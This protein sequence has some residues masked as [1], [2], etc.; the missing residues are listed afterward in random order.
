MAMLCFGLYTSQ[1]IAQAALVDG[2]K[3]RQPIQEEATNFHT[4]SEE[5]K[6][7][8]LYDEANWGPLADSLFETGIELV[9]FMLPV[10]NKYADENI[11]QPG[12]EVIGLAN[13]A[14]KAIKGAP[15]DGKEWNRNYLNS[16]KI[17]LE[18]ST[19]ALIQRFDQY[20]YTSL[21]NSIPI[22]R[23]AKQK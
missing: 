3:E 6:G 16:D 17:I 13:S 12:A 22:T 7:S 21:V 10:E 11:E 15:L 4:I 1:S 20:L 5:R 2:L 8:M 9:I 14:M 23:F 18:D 19:Q